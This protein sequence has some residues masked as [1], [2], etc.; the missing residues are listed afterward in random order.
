VGAG[1]AAAVLRATAPIVTPGLP[2]EEVV[3]VAILAEAAA[4]PWDSSGKPLSR[5]G[6]P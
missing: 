3:V 4:S 2:E 1:A 6:K 5:S